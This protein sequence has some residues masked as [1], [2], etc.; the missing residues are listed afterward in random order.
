IREGGMWTNRALAIADSGVSAAR[1]RVTCNASIFALFSGDLETASAMARESLIIWR[2]LDDAH[3]IAVALLHLGLVE[4]SRLHW[5]EAGRFYEEAVA[6]WRPLEK[7][8][9]LAIVLALL[10]GVAHGQGDSE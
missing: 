4:E 9:S 1:A 5:E 6:I 3:G 7:N 2:A 10:G 8:H